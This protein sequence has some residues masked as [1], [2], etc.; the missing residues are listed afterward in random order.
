MKSRKNASLTGEEKR[1]KKIISHL[2]RTRI[3]NAIESSQNYKMRKLT[4][5][6]KLADEY[7]IDTIE[8]SDYRQSKNKNE[9]ESI[10]P[11]SKKDLVKY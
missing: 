9:D 7:F 8:L 11:V 5:E 6:E 4:K 2:W 3:K 10:F 1:L